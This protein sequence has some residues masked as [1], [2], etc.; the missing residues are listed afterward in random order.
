MSFAH[1][2]I[3]GL[4]SKFDQVKILLLNSKLS[5]LVLGETFLHEGITDAELYIPGYKFMRVDRA[6]SSG[7]KEGGGVLLCIQQSSIILV[8]SRKLNT[9]VLILNVL[10]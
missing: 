2:N 3:R 10:C 1:L 6:V 4:I 8:K 7:K 9:A 5:C